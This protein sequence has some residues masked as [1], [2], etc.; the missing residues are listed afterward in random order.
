MVGYSVAFFGWLIWLFGCGLV[1]GKTLSFGC[2]LGCCLCLSCMI[3]GVAVNSVG[4]LI[5]C[6]VLFLGL[7][8]IVV[9]GYL[10]C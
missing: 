2:F 1:V 6:V 8:L 3:S 10:N 5:L 4:I 7:R 9:F